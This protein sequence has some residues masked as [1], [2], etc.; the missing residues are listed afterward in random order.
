MVG[1][2]DGEACEPIQK[3]SWMGGLKAAHT[4]RAVVWYV[5]Y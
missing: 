3:L 4:G 1:R 5:P 2:T